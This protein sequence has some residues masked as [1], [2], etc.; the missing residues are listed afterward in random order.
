MR[1]KEAVKR[2]RMRL[3]L[4]S[5][6]HAGLHNSLLSNNALLLLQRQAHHVRY[7]LF[8][9]LTPPNI[10]ASTATCTAIPR[11]CA[12]NGKRDAAWGGVGVGHRE[13]ALLL[14]CARVGAIVRVG[15]FGAPGA[16]FTTEV[17]RVLGGR[18]HDVAAVH[19]CRIDAARTAGAW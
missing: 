14:S 15:R 3:P 7:L 8:L 6:A 18:R 10:S 9:R 17:A 16:P 4:P 5:E 2:G 19:A 12:P 1:K 11:H 13:K